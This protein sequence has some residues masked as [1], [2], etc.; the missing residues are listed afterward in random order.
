MLQ[1]AHT[2][3]FGELKYRHVNITSLRIVDVNS[4]AVDDAVKDLEVNRKNRNVRLKPQ[5][6][7]VSNN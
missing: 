2:L 1:D 4:T 5:S 6:L 7:K 3:D